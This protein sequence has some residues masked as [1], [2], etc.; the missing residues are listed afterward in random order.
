MLTAVRI[1]REPPPGEDALVKLAERQLRRRL[2]RLAATLGVRMPAGEGGERQR[3][4]RSN[5]GR[6]APTP[7]PPPPPQPVHVV[8]ASATV[9]RNILLQ[10]RKL[11][12]LVRRVCLNPADDAWPSLGRRGRMK[13]FT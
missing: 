2:A 10:L 7:P 1:M 3:T 8:A 13:A 12:N 9:S 6:R 5:R 11:F 4:W